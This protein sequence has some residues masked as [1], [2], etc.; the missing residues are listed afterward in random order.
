M[1]EYYSVVRSPYLE[2]F[3]ILGMKW[4]VRR[5]QNPDGSLTPEGVAR[6]RAKNK[7]QAGKI[8]DEYLNFC[9]DNSLSS[10]EK[11]FDLTGASKDKLETI[12]DAI[13]L[14][15][16]KETELNKESKEILK[17]LDDKTRTYYESVT[18]IAEASSFYGKKPEE[19]TMEDIG[20]NGFMACLEDG[21]Q[22]EINAVSYYIHEKGL[23]ERA[24]K[25]IKDY[26]DSWNGTKD[27]LESTLSDAFEE[28]GANDV[29]YG[30]EGNKKL[31]SSLA[32]RLTYSR[33]FGPQKD[34]P[35]FLGD[36]RYN[37]HH[38]YTDAELKNIESAKR[39]IDHIEGNKDRN[40]WWYVNEAA[41]NLGM[42]STK[43]EDM[44]QAD[45]DRLNAEI[46]NLRAAQH[47]AMTEE[48]FLEHHGI[49]GMKWGI[50][51][52]QNPD[53][54]LTEE[55]R[56][57]YGDILTKDQMNNYVRSYNLRTG[58]KKTINKNTVFKTPHGS[59][60]YKGRR[61]DTDTEVNDPGSETDK[62][63]KPKKVSEMTDAELKAA[64]DRMNDELIFKQRY[65]ALNPVKTTLTQQVVNAT[66]DA[67]VSEIPKAV[68]RGIGKYIENAISGSSGNDSKDKKD[69]KDKI[70]KS[71]KDVTKTVSDTKDGKKKTTSDPAPRLSGTIP[72]DS[73]EERSSSD[74][75]STKYNSKNSN[76]MS[77]FGTRL[78]DVPSSSRD[79]SG[80]VRSLFSSSSSGSSASPLS[81]R[82]NDLSAVRESFYDDLWDD[83]AKNMRHSM[84]LH[85]KLRDIL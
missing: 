61:I 82:V 43:A 7:M 45:W 27:L 78:S 57:R 71:I 22:Q 34:Y 25:V 51:R 74:S 42:S 8:Y 56:R 9:K 69:V 14:R 3:G 46:R 13:D 50:R 39:V 16:R 58:K 66:K 63:T 55:G 48:E 49:L 67:I 15:D 29:K 12:E 65:A 26:S 2:H 52:F 53:G 47:S 17:D 35:E 31:S 59:Y 40:T 62:K 77:Y 54:S 68:G 10:L 24:D 64:N 21:Q 6:Y 76:A 37:G 85:V 33:L 4:G 28:V 41:E 23:S 84:F 20:N 79:A 44:T 32:T 80:T 73:H 18:E 60:D 70:D 1:N 75:G 19:L 83:L 36:I 30:S 38:D 5:F 72:E 81:T 11:I